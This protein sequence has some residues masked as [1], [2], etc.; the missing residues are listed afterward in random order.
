MGR[1]G[2]IRQ[3]LGGRDTDASYECLACN[4]R[5]DRQYQVCPEC[6]GYDIRHV[7]WLDAPSSEERG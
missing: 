5:F 6:N 3:L 4:A 2:A 1:L 7:E